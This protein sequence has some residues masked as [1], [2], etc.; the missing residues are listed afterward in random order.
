MSSLDL[1]VIIPCYRDAPHLRQN[2]AEVVRTLQQTR[3]SWELILVNDASPDRDL[4]VARE[5]IAEWPEE[6]IHLINHEHN[7]GR[8]RAV[9]DGM[10]VA[11]GRHAGF[12]DIDLEVPAHYIPAMVRRLENGADVVCAHR[13]YK[14]KYGLLHRAIISGG[15]IALVR[16]MLGVDLHDTEAGYKFFRLDAIKPVLESCR[17]QGWF[18]D[19][20]IMVR[21]QLAGLKMDFLPVLFL[22]N[23]DK[24]STVKVVSD[25]ITQ[26]KRLVEFR[27]ELKELRAKRINGASAPELATANGGN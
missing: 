12:L 21:S 23:P 15:Y 19:T 7:T 3:L 2:V 22:R 27:A 13:I 6:T 1:S 25:S 18:W 24:S 9:M 10:A 20:E 26:W 4:E 14:T 11:N 8:G 16:K 17:D 5:V